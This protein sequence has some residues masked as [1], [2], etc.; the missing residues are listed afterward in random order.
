[1]AAYK[2]LALAKNGMRRAGRFWP[3]QT[4]IP[5]DLSPEEFAILSKEPGLHVELDVGVPQSVE[6]FRE[7]ISEA[8][9]RIAR[10]ED[11]KA[12]LEREHLFLI[13]AYEKRGDQNAALTKERDALRLKLDSIPTAVSVA[14]APAAEPE[15]ALEPAKD[16]KTEKGSK[17]K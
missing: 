11:Q 12:D 2:V 4:A 15:P 6:G 3:G 9:E 14:V 13:E 10:L 1:M 17:S 7:E 8:G 16:P 5:V